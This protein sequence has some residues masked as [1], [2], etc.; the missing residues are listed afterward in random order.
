MRQHY[1]VQL[2]QLTASVPHIGPTYSNTTTPE[3]EYHTGWYSPVF[4]GPNRHNIQ[5]TTAYMDVTYNPLNDK[6]NFNRIWFQYSTKPTTEFNSTQCK[7][8]IENIP[9][10]AALFGYSE[11]VESQLGPFQDHETVGVIVV[12]C[13]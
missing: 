3:Y 1:W 12:Q 11:Y 8:V 13:P 6:A 10:W 9:L 4:I 5:F 2:T 7:C